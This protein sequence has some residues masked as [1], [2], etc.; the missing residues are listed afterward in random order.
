MNSRVARDWDK[1]AAAE[2][3]A[4]ASAYDRLSSEPTAVSSR[5]PR[6]KGGL[7]TGTYEGRG[8]DRWQYEVTAGG[9]IWYFVDDPTTAE[10]KT[11]KRKGKGSRPRRRV[12]IEA[13][14]I[15]HPKRTE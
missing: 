10:G 14:Y 6:L 5:Q 8:F 13:V 4:L 3:N 11:P 7:E 2:P 1:L 15:G 12:L 9:R